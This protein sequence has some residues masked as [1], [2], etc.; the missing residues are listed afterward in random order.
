MGSKY[1][2]TQY[3]DFTAKD[4]DYVELIDNPPFC[5]KRVVRGQGL[6][7]IQLRNKPKEELI[8]D[9]L[10]EPLALVVGKFLVPEFAQAIGLTIDD[11][12]KLYPL[13]TRLDTKH[14]YERLI[15]TAYLENNCF[16]LTDA[17]RRLA[18]ESYLASRTIIP[19]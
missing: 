3:A 17:Q 6:D 15:Y 12:P 9:A 8:Q 11:L 1:F 5:K 10:E 7:L 2:F 13:I 4:T 16:C 19:K 14:Q 18:Y